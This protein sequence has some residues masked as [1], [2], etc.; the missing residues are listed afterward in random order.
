MNLG[1]RYLSLNYN[2]VW[3][4]VS[5]LV[6]LF[7]YINILPLELCVLPSSELLHYDASHKSRPASSAHDFNETN[8]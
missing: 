5:C 2:I 4:Q 1:R 6:S 8:R 3:L 7:V